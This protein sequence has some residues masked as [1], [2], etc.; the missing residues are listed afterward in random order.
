MKR[1]GA[2]NAPRAEEKKMSDKHTERHCVVVT[3]RFSVKSVDDAHAQGGDRSI[4]V[5]GFEGDGSEHVNATTGNYGF[6]IGGRRSTATA[7]TGGI[8]VSGD[9]GTATTGAGGVAVSLGDGTATTLDG[10]V[11]FAG[12]YN[13]R[14]IG[15]YEA[16]TAVA[17]I[18]GVAEVA[19]AGVATVLSGTSI[20]ANW[21]LASVREGGKASVG[22]GGV[23][24]AWNLTGDYGLKGTPDNVGADPALVTAI[25]AGDGGIIIS[26]VL[27]ENGRRQPVIGLVGDV[28]ARVQAGLEPGKSYKLADGK[29]ALV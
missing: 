28:Q 1:F 11:A 16:A 26:F 13:G 18:N 21:G 27:G 15:Q 14:A 3:K 8:S 29:F 17:R 2:A 22:P 9:G 10:G 7:L 24:I 20:A 25:G 23:A 12:G 5:A 19:Y 6:A 4:V